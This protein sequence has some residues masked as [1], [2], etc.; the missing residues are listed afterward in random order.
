MQIGKRLLYGHE[1][2]RYDRELSFKLCSSR[3]TQCQMN[4]VPGICEQNINAPRSLCRL[5]ECA[6]HGLIVCRI[7]NKAGA[8]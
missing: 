5:L 4:V 1:G 7:S 6:A 8:G 2:A 3:A